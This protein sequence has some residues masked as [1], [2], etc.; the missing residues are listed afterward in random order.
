[1]RAILVALLAFACTAPL[2][3][4]ASSSPPAPAST[5]APSPTATPNPALDPRHGFVIALPLSVRVRSETE[6]RTIRSVP[7]TGTTVVLSPDGLLIAYWAQSSGSQVL[8]ELH[9]ASLDGGSPDRTLVTL[10]GEA[11]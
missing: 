10:D 6:D 11:G 4:L 8:N 5:P 9:V 7:A 2:A 3:S 1:M